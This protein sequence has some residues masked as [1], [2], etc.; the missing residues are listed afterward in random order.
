LRVKELKDYLQD[1]DDDMQVFTSIWGVHGEVRQRVN[2]SVPE[3]EGNI[4]SNKKYLRIS[5]T[6]F[7]PA[8]QIDDDEFSS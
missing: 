6:D 8:H 4:S 1:K 7:C 2:L 5:W 3:L